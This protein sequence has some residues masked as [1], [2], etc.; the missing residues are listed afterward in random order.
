MQQFKISLPDELRT[1][2]DA[3]AAKANHSTAEEIRQRLEQT[4]AQDAVDPATRTVAAD[5]AGLAEA[6]GALARIAWHQHTDVHRAFVEA[7]RVYLE[8]LAPTETSAA[9][10][11]LFGFN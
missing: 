11:D 5:I 6:L 7:A 9:V 10:H 2:L 8:G 1:R 3:A 4:L